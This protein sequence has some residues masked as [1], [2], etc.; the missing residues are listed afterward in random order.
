MIAIKEAYTKAHNEFPEY[1]LTECV[2]I[3]NA[4]AFYF[5]PGGGDEIPGVPYVAVN[6]ESGSVVFLTIPPFDNLELIQNGKRL[7]I[8]NLTDK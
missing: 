6:K 3:G 7:D 8:G 4:Y 2:D 5:S 1:T